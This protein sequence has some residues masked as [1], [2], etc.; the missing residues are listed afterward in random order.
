[1]D[2]TA[3]IGLISPAHAGLTTENIK[4]EGMKTALKVQT[5]VAETSKGA[6]YTLS[7]RGSD[8]I[9]SAYGRTSPQAKEAT[10]L[11]KSV[12]PVKTTKTTLPATPPTP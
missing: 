5:E 3:L 2:L 1:V 10:A 6:L 11:R 9:I 7:S 4:Q 8:M 12:R